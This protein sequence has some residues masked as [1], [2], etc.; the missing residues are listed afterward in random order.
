MA[1]QVTSYR[2][3]A[4]QFQQAK[5]TAA[6]TEAGAAFSAARG[7]LKGAFASYRVEKG[8]VDSKG[9]SERFFKNESAQEKANRKMNEWLKKPVEQEEKADGKAEERFVAAAGDFESA[10]LASTK[11]EEVMAARAA[12]KAFKAETLTQL[13]AGKTVEELQKELD[14]LS[15]KT[16]A[17]VAYWSLKLKA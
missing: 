13:K 2:D 10:F 9:V 15:A 8:G 6:A 3:L 4:A 5:T 17:K 1:N 12:K 11:S 7:L 16:I 14:G